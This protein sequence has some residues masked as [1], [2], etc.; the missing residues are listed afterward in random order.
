MGCSFLKACFSIACVCLLREVCVCARLC[1]L[2]LDATQQITKDDDDLTY[3]CVDE[4]DGGKAL[5]L[6]KA[7]KVLEL[8]AHRG[9]VPRLPRPQNVGA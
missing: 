7:C 5:V 9:E 1:C 2:M 3:L 8:V 4:V 6:G